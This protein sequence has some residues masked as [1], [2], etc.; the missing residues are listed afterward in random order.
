MLRNLRNNLYLL[1][2][3]FPPPF[4][5]TGTPQHF[6]ELIKC[7]HKYLRPIIVIDSIANKNP[8]TSIAV[9]GFFVLYLGVSYLFNFHLATS[10]Q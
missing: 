7:F 3:C 4:S 1:F 5:S 6:C 2:F 8:L 9:N 10:S